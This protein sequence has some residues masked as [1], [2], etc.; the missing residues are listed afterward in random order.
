MNGFTRM[1][2]V[3]AGALAGGVIALVVASGSGSHSSSTTTIT[4]TSRGYAVPTSLA[5][6]T[7]RGLTINQIYKNDSP[8][9]VDIVVTSTT[10]GG[11][12]GPFGGG[13]Q[14]T[15]GEGAGVVYD[16]SGDI[17]TDEHVVANAT[18]VKV[19]FQ[20]GRPP[21]PRLSAPIPRPTSA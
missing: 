19:K 3:V 1:I 13:T 11:G 6:T 9:V 5:G 2:P 8:G 21:P 7:S 16:T 10:T 12:T 14:Q 18:T 15:Q 17:L 4:Q 20:D